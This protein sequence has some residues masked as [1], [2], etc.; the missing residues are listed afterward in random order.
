MKVLQVNAVNEILSTGRTC[1]EISDYLYSCGDKCYTAYSAGGSG[2]NAFCISPAWECKY[3]ALMSR[4]TGL[5]GYFSEISTANLFNLIR[6]IKPDVVHLRNLHAN[7]LHLN[8]LFRYLAAHDIATVITLHDCWVY[9]GKCTHYTSIGCNKW[10]T[11]CFA[12]P[13]LKD[14][15]ASWLFD[16]TPKMWRDKKNGWLSIPRLAV[17]GVSD[18]ITNEAKKS[19]MFANATI[20]QRIYNWIDLD[21][22]CPADPAAAKGKIGFSGKKIILGV[23]SGWSNKK[24]LDKFIALAEHLKED[25]QIVLVGNMPQILLPDNVISIPATAD[26]NELVTYYNAADVFLQLSMEETFG[27]VVAEALACGTPVITNT[28]TANPEL[29]D[30]SC[31]AVLTNELDTSVVLSCMRQVLHHGRDYYAPHCREKAKMLFDKNR[32]VEQY[33]SIYFKLTEG[34]A[35]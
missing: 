24:G 23:A 28:G 5:Q 27:K 7:Y 18:W 2:Q 11:G 1:S 33:R 15:N 9:T 32:N 6:G 16:R 29:V 4:I 19:P 34:N 35:N 17:I 12:C 3:H 31:G 30:E 20:I 25:E 10:Q 8:K 14:D 22:F 13:K 26:V 21:V